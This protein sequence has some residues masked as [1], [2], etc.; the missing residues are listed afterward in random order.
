M[1]AR[2]LRASFSSSSLVVLV[3]KCRRESHQTRFK[4]RGRCTVQR[5]TQLPHLCSAVRRIRPST[6]QLC[7]V[8]CTSLETLG[9]PQDKRAHNVANHAGAAHGALH[10]PR[11]LDRTRNASLRSYQVR[12]LGWT[13]AR[14]RGAWP[15]RTMCKAAHL[16]EHCQPADEHHP[17]RAAA[18]GAHQERA[19]RGNEPRH[20]H[21]CRNDV[22][23]GHAGLLPCERL[24]AA[25]AQQACEYI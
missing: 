23:H 24:K 8:I 7:A 17:R 14:V 19:G 3:R 11:T 5:C 4:S 1:R 20:T 13:A 15:L 16:S 21:G 25:D 18:H 22:H 6:Q 2:N 12:G 9:S 10:W